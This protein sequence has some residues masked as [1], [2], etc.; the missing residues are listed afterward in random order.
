MKTITISGLPGTGKTTISQLLH[1]HYKIPYVYT[2]EIFR[3]LAKEHKMSLSEF[4]TFAE[5]HPEIDKQLD[6][7]QLH[8]LRKGNVILEGRLAGWLAHQHNIPAIKI[9]LIADVQT[10]AERIVKR[11]GDDVE[12]RKQ[13]MLKR[14]QSEKQRY[15]EFY[16]IDI[17]DT[18]IYDIIIDSS[19]KPPESIL[20]II[21][22]KN[23][24]L[25][26]LNYDE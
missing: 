17:S 11:E 18:S 10:R 3:S 4:S 22:K 16:H 7:K 23:K 5:Q 21:L 20:E 12:I 25:R 15:H 26:T 13:E 1:E 6:E 24:I 9:L 8:I 14:E 2:G 19:D